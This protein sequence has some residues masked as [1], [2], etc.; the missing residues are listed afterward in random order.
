MNRTDILAPPT[1]S[2]VSA[3][4]FLLVAAVMA[5]LPTLHSIYLHGDD[6]FFSRWG[7]FSTAEVMNFNLIVGRPLAGLTYRILALAGSVSEV[8]AYRMLSVTNL[9]ITGFLI[10]LWLRRSNISRTPALAAS[11]IIITLP[12]FQSFAA[13]AC[14]AAFGVATTL[15]AAALLLD[16]HADNLQ[17]LRERTAHRVLAISLL[18]CSLSLYQP[19]VLVYVA[20]LVVPLLSSAQTRF[21]WREQKALLTRVATI[22]VATVVYYLGWRAWLAAAGIPPIGGR[23]DARVLVSDY[24]ARLEWFLRTPLVEALNLWNLQPSRPLAIACTAALVVAIGSVL[25]AR[26]AQAS[27]SKWRDAGWRLVACILLF[28]ACFAISLASADPAPA[29][30]TYAALET[31]IV[32]ILVIGL[33]Q[34]LRR[35]REFERWKNWYHCGLGAMLIGAIAAAN[36]T[37][38]DYFV[39][40][41]SVEFGHLKSRIRQAV[42]NVGIPQRIH[43]IPAIRSAT[44]AI[45]RNEFGEPVV[46]HLPNLRPIVWA[47]LSELGIHERI[48]VS[49]TIPAYPDLWIE[50]RPELI[51]MQL[52]AFQVPPDTSARVLVINM[53]GFSNR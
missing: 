2:K 10:F 38:S 37:T 18:V 7:D 9:A 32:L 5:Y 43:V 30:R 1:S 50:Y 23:Y 16:A 21:T 3:F 22:S 6:V 46:R 11:A 4:A 24:G 40:P 51:N 47:A 33:D 35:V 12:P 45:E 17:T 44:V 15:A 28:P 20:L 49:F 8:N 42:A 36:I 29:Y 34:G 14:Y 19:S 27:P 41:D 26:E 52:R 31:L 39:M 48:P 25:I 53:A 13:V